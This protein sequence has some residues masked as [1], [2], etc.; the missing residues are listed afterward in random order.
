MEIKNIGRR[1]KEMREIS[2]TSVESLS[3]MLDI[4]EQDYLK[5]ENGDLDFS[6]TF[7]EKLAKFYNIEIIE[8]LSGYSPKLHNYQ[9][10]R[11]GEGVPLK[12]RES[13]DYL[14][15]ASL[16]KHKSAEPFMVTAKYNEEEQNK[17]IAL[18][19]HNDEE[20]NIVI[21]GSIK[22]AIGAN[23]EV[24]SEGD[25]I[26]YDASIPHGMIA[27]GGKDCQFLSVI[28]NKKASEK[29]ISEYVFASDKSINN[30]QDFLYK[31]YVTPTLNK[32]GVLEK[33]QFHPTPDFN[34]A[35]DIVD[36]IAEKSP[37]KRAMLWLSVDKD[38]KDFSFKDIKYY[39]D[40]CANFF[41]DLG[42]KKGDKVMLILKRH[43]EFWFSIIAL[44]KLG[45]IAI[46]ATHL[47]TEKDLLYRFDKAHVKAVV[48]TYKNLNIVQECEK[49]FTKYHIEHKILV[50]ERE[51]WVN[52]HEG[53]DKS[54]DKL[55]R[56][57]NDIKDPMIM[58]FTSG[59]SG[60]PKI[61]CH[62]FSY[63]LGHFVTAKYWHNVDPNG[64]H[65]TISDTG[66]AKSVWGKLYGQWLC[67]AAVFTYDFEK[68]EAH[69]LLPLFKEHNITTFCAPPTMFRFFIKENLSEY[70]LSSLK[71]ATVAGEAL[72]GEVF[73]QFLK[74]TNIKLMEGFG[75][76]ETTLSIANLVGTNCKVGSM[77]KPNPQYDIALVD[78]DDMPVKVGE[79]GEI[80]IRTDKEAP[81]GLFDGYYEDEEITSRTWHDGIYHTGDVAWQDEDGYLWYVGRIDDLIKSSGYRIGPFE[82]ESVIME[83]PYVL[84]CA[85]TGVPDEVRGQIVKATIVLTK[86]TVATE[87]LKKEVQEYVK[88]H[89]APYKYPR[90]VEFVTELPK[91]ISGKIRRVEIRKNS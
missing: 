71:Y 65:F 55:E 53:L 89:T 1:I 13:F 29:G 25:S 3:I 19:T 57:P 23:T 49:A 18:S 6:V 72:N 83:L 54:S 36:K 39:S 33:I 82:I 91:T 42:I 85:V 80:V 32:N 88:K 47:L 50:G 14:Q 81:M 21:K 44:H 69:D 5:A 67:E 8:L 73:D 75:Q 15:L 58:F 46:P 52:Y 66:W 38:V 56:I 4:T 63:P 24:L 68:F 31:K 12:R 37:D 10:A 87:Q 78:K 17:D 20:F 79:V 76:T 26:Y 64:L 90:I 61:A 60:Y 11:S 9:V 2:D 86:N 28:I 22:I 74:A 84:E 41:K 34:F 45:A 16:F 35:Y 30:N 70:D 27:V 7:L 77:G 40:K 62:N 43:Y 51:G 59:T 48:C